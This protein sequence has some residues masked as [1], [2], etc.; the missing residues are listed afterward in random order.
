MIDTLQ[1]KFALHKRRWDIGYGVTSFFFK[2][3][4]V[5]GFVSSLLQ[6]TFIILAVYTF[7]CYFI[8]WYWMKSKL[9]DAEA[10][11]RNQYDPF[12]REMRNKGKI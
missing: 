11:V 10:E 8:G 12:M 5:F 7:S 3:I 4:A 1:Y 9:L 6:E 2:L